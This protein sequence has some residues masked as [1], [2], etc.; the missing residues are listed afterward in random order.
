MPIVSSWRWEGAG[1]A[2]MLHDVE[3]ERT[4]S[5]PRDIRTSSYSLLSWVQKKTHL[6]KDIIYIPSGINKVITIIVNNSQ[7]LF[8]LSYRLDIWLEI[9]WR[10]VTQ[11]F[12][13]IHLNPKEDLLV[14]NYLAVNSAWISQ[15]NIWETMLWPNNCAH[16]KRVIPSD[17]KKREWFI[18]LQN[19]WFLANNCSFTCIYSQTWNL[20]K[21]LHTQ[22]FRLKVLHRKSA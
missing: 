8:K 19:E 3:W 12:F 5:Q 20:S 1:L 16:E 14:S 13:Q 10:K 7:F 6:Q 9:I 22:I 2:L 18:A 15:K 21:I 4:Q 17:I 11:V